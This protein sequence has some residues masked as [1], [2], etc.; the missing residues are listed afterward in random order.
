MTE[1][2]ANPNRQRPGPAEAIDWRAGRTWVL[3]GATSLCFGGLSALFCLALEGFVYLL[4]AREPPEGRVFVVLLLGT[5][6][7]IAAGFI[8][9]RV[10]PQTRETKASDIPDHPLHRDRNSWPGNSEDTILQILWPIS[11]IASA[12]GGTELATVLFPIEFFSGAS[13]Y[14]V[15]LLVISSFDLPIRVIARRPPDKTGA[16]CD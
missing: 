16:G 11:A 1:P 12:W 5:C 9:E 15:L 4:F 14:A 3:L 7:A 6:L 8:L 10:K 2:A 13:L